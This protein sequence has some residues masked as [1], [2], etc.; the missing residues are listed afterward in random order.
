MTC[1]LGECRCRAGFET[2]FPECLDID[3]CA[4]HPD[5]CGEAAYCFNL[6]GGYLCYCREGFRRYPPSYVCSKISECGRDCGE[7]ASC[8]Y[9]ETEEKFGCVCHEGFVEL[10]DINGGCVRL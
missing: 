8:K 2:S 9:L 1:V 4:V 6:V 3:E 5:I 7:N 10:L